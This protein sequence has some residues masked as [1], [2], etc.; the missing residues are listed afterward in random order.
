MSDHDDTEQ[1]LLSDRDTLVRQVARSLLDH[2]LG[3]GESLFDPSRPAWSRET[4][5]DLYQRYN[6]KPDMGKDTFLVKLRRQ[7]DD[8]PDDVILLTAELLTLHALPLRNF[9]QPAKLARINE[10]LSWMQ[11]P[12]EL[13]AD[14]AAALAESSWSGGAGVHTMLWKWLQDAVVLVRSWWEHPAAERAQAL[15]DPWKWE[16]V[17]KSFP[18]MPS[19]R[20]ALLYLA[21]PWYF[22]P[23]INLKQKQAIRD[24]FSYR[25]ERR[26][27]D[28]DRD[29]YEITLAVQRDYGDYVL[30]WTDPFVREWQPKADSEQQRAWLVRPVPGGQTLT[31]QWQREGLVSLS[32]RHLG[33]IDPEASLSAIRQDVEAGYHNLDYSRRATLALDFY[34]FMRQMAE[35]H[36]IVTLDGDHFF[37]GV[38]TGPPEYDPGRP[39]TELRRSVTWQDPR[40]LTVVSSS[41]ELSGELN[42]QGTVVD[43]TSAYEYVSGLAGVAVGTVTTASE[44]EKPRQSPLSVP[45]LK[46][47]TTEL[48]ADL[49]IE[50]SWLQEV[51]DV[52]Q[53]RQ[54]IVFYGPPGT[55]KTYLAQALAE[56]LAGLGTGAVSLVQFH[57]SYAYEDFFEGY[58]PAGEDD[59]ATFKLIPGPLRR[60]ATAA[61]R[62]P[63][64][65]YILIIDEINRANL[66]KVFGELYFLL[67]YRKKRI[68]LQYS[69][70]EL[71]SLPP[72]VFL[73]GTMNTADRSIALVDAALRRRFAFMELHPDEPPV[74]N[75]LANWLDDQSL[76]LERHWLLRSL[77]DSIGEEDRDFK[78]GPSYLMRP[79]AA[80][81]EGLDRIWRYDLL[82][83]LDEH[84]YGRLSRSEVLRRFGL[85]AIRARITA[86]S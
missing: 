74:R 57:P 45:R 32:A 84:Y 46:A 34:A 67:E 36:I 61:A 66:P 31:R 12:V 18:G 14:V 9:G 86:E 20:E 28:L 39:D 78:I 41:E 19:L 24:A 50:Q 72:N 63:D 3:G 51:I 73:I 37:V 29:L 21:F 33:P 70:E 68:G 38:I 77:N 54:Q 65:P 52:F 35:G 27:G 30:Y 48:A 4:V 22:L 1:I 83:L 15:S 16:E 7:L 82:P 47:A 17:I 10:V 6:E 13:P 80:T 79:E 56:H 44:S 55:G 8:A 75:L 43:V 53:S 64:Q 2:A 71:F 62:D 25:I 81:P 26:T 40:P 60:L 5:Y 58:R 85:D 23:M 49:R 69:P 76:S 42:A 11:R 59:K